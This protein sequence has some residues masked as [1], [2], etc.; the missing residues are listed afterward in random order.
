MA[1]LEYAYDGTAPLGERIVR[2]VLPGNQSVAEVDELLV[3]MTNY[4]AQGS[5]GWVAPRFS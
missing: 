3:V 5:D 1:G 2:A 4:M